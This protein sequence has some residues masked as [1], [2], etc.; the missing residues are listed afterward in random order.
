[1]IDINKPIGVFLHAS[2]KASIKRL[3]RKISKAILH[4]LDENI[5]THANVN[6]LEYS[7]KGLDAHSSGIVVHIK[8][9]SHLARMV[10]PYDMCVRK[11]VYSLGSILEAKNWYRWASTSL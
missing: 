11:F 4:E 2:N 5:N 3:E 10:L 6:S 1:M 7:V 8:A 9:K